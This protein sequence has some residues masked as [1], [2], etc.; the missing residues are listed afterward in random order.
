MPQKKLS[1]Q[2]SIVAELLVKGFRNTEICSKIGIGMTTVSTYKKRILLKT[3]SK[4]VIQL[5]KNLKKNKK[6]FQSIKLS[7]V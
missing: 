3:E 6:I 4:N 1:N 7:V 2:E 5:V